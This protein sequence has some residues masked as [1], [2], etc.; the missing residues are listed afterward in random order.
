MQLK[1]DVQD[2][3]ITLRLDGEIDHHAACWII[4]RITQEIELSAP[5][6]VILD[7]SGVK[8]MDSSGIAVAMN[9]N[10][11]MKQLGGS[12]KI[13]NVSVQ[14]EKVFRA[15]GMQQFMEMEGSK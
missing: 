6:Q 13:V 2:R 11:L 3:N 14:A 12:V 15:A 10:R 7:F 1:T 4:R 5:M 8:F 9:T